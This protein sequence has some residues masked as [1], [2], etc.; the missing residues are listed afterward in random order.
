[1]PPKAGLAG[2]GQPGGRVG[3]VTP[4]RLHPRDRRLQGAAR[5]RAQPLPTL[6]HPPFLACGGEQAR[7]PLPRVQ[8]TL[9]HAADEPEPARPAARAGALRKSAL[10]LRARGAPCPAL[11]AP[12][13]A[14]EPAAQWRGRDSGLLSVRLL[15][16]RRKI[17]ARRAAPAPVAAPDD[18]GELP[19]SVR[20]DQGRSQDS[21]YSRMTDHK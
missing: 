12:R 10:G 11:E 13:P 19:L 4:L 16:R 6:R 7:V 15:G 17:L 14:E 1:L 2:V 5:A 21:E 9:R 8:C 3:A 20:V 18:R